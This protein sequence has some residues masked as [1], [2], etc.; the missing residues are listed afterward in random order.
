MAKYW[1]MKTEPSSYS[2]DDLARDGWTYWDGV[3]NYQARNLLRDEI[4]V[5]DG[6]L[7][8]H[9]S[10]DPIGV[11]GIARV[12]RAGYPDFTALDPNNHHHDPK[13]TEAEPIWHMVDLEFVGKF[14]RFVTLADLKA[15]AALK[16]MMVCQ[17]GARLSIQPVERAHFEKVKS[18]GK[19]FVP[20]AGG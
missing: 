7:V 3:R 1:L 16:R 13:S 14:R 19:G 5:G 6:V 20:G 10:S 8:Y 18:L 11:A 12:R 2:I 4:A 9:S 17:P 15:D